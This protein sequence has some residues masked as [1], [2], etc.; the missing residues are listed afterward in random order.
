[1]SDSQIFVYQ[2]NETISLDVRFENETVWLTQEQ[3]ALLFGTQ[4]PAITKHL[5]NIYRDGE[6]E[7]DSTCSILEHLG[8]GGQQS[9]RTK[10][11][12]LDAI[13][14]V[15]YRVNSRNA[16][17]FRRWASRVLKDYLLQG[18]AF[19]RRL[20][21]L[22]E[23]VDRRFASQNKRLDSLDEKMELFVRTNSTPIQG[24][25]YDGQLWDARIF[26]DRLVK[27]A[28]KSL[29]LIDNWVTLDTLD[30]LARKNK[31]VLLTVVTSGHN[32]RKGNPKLTI[33]PA[34]VKK[35]NA[36]YPKLE[37][38]VNERF[39][40]RFLILD[41]TE[42]YLIGASLKDLGKKCFAFT[43]MDSKEIPNVKAKIQES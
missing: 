42:L 38:K 15:G 21:E 39:H 23:K 5:A 18:F 37:I 1:M 29:L 10:F 35:F 36:Q 25:F 8:R 12:N 2:P 14:S 4:R 40:D 32:D 26:V 6:L 31:G 30:M 43:R 28:K 27:S 22:E 41:D 17:L 33:L 7:E 3:I 16:T 20:N 9:Y 24:I 11:Y 34:D 19:N 13:L